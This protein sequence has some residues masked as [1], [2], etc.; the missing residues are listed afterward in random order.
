MNIDR[1]RRAS[2]LP[3]LWLLLGGGANA[4]AQGA[5]TSAEQV[6][7]AVSPKVW[8]VKAAQP[9]GSQF[10]IGSAVLIAPG[11]FITAC[12]VVEKSVGV[13]LS[14]GNATLKVD[15]VLRDPDDRRDLCLLRVAGRLDAAPVQIAPIST[16]KVGQRVY[17]IASPRGLELSLTDGLISSLRR[18][19]ESQV[20]I[21]QS[22]TPVTSG[23]SGGGLFDE[24]GR[25][26]GVVRSVATA[27]ENFA[28]SYP[29][30]W[31]AQLPE[32][33]ARE[34]AAWQNEMKALGVRFS[35]DGNVVG[36]GFA[37]LADLN[38]LPVPA[39]QREPVALAYRQFLLLAAP[40][41]FVFT[42]DGKFGTFSNAAEFSKFRAQCRQAGVTFKLYAVDNAVVWQAA[43]AAA[44]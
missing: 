18:E 2:V 15:E 29:A 23:S 31:V 42:S 43:A 27:T 22:S 5:G 38:A 28:F 24:H 26:V 32:R 19:P 44:R 11:R 33:Y 36:S 25:L 17:V 12:H 39:A 20:P 3:A 7:A 16:L 8:T 30:E 35:G 10:M 9:Q 14:N 37:A 13:T 21:I 41:A 34:I 6:F 40:R 4:F 1:K